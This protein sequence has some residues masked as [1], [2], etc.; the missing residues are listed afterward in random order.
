MQYIKIAV[1]PP[2][3]ALNLLLLKFTTSDTFETI[4][5][6]KYSNSLQRNV[7]TFQYTNKD[8]YLSQQQQQDIIV[9]YKTQEHRHVT[10]DETQHYIQRY[11]KRSITLYLLDPITM[12]PLSELNDVK[13]H[14]LQT[15]LSIQHLLTQTIEDFTNVSIQDIINFTHLRNQKRISK[16]T[17]IQYIEKNFDILSKIFGH[18]LWRTTTHNVAWKKL[19]SIVSVTKNQEL[20]KIQILWKNDFTGSKDVLQ[21]RKFPISFLCNC[22]EKR[23]VYAFK[24]LFYLTTCQQYSTFTLFEIFDA[25]FGIK[26]VH[27]AE[28]V[29]SIRVRLF[30]YFIEALNFITDNTSLDVVFSST[31]LSECVKERKYKKNLWKMLYT[32][33][34]S[35]NLVNTYTD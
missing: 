2:F 17:K 12:T 6:E 19:Q 14:T 18:C 25:I 11:V 20:F 33:T 29:N 4:F 23:N 16:H 21:Y 30:K 22:N 32:E 24:L 8:I 7:H 13:L 35:I 28:K 3:R 1:S 27:H 31:K 26:Q 10:D 34:L 5:T 15:A 9:K